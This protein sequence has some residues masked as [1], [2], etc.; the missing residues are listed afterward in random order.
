MGQMRDLVGP[1]RAAAAGV[2][3]PAEHTGIEE[4]AINDQLLAALEQIE[5]AEL[6]LGPAELVSL[7]HRHPRHASA[8]GRQGITG[9][10][11]GLLL[12]KKLLPRGLPLLL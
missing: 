9:A 1:E 5:Q 2:I 4:G 10:G 12:H 7:L 8:L 11:E 6:A 3:G